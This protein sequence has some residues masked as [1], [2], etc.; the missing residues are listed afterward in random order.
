[1]A[2]KH[3]S[4]T[5]DF[6][7]ELVEKALY[8]SASVVQLGREQNIHPVLIYRWIKKYQQGALNKPSAASTSPKTQ[9]KDLEALV[10]RLMIDN[11]LLK[12]ALRVVQEQPKPNVILSVPTEIPLER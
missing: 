5:P 3:R 10:G 2:L 9:I 4:F 1:M 6:K 11:E 7:K 8:G 12:K